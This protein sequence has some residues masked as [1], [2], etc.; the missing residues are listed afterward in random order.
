MDSSINWTTDCGVVIVASSLS[1][2][3][4]EIVSSRD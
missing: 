1:D 2:L 4:A 3:I